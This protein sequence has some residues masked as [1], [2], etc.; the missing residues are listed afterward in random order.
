LSNSVADVLA[1]ARPIAGLCLLCIASLLAACGGGG[2]SSAVPTAVPPAIATQPASAV[3]KDGQPASFSAVADG[4]TPLSY[5]WQRNRRNIDGANEPSY[6]L[7]AAQ[8]ADNGVQ[9]TVV[10]TNPVGST[11][12][13]PATLTVDPIAPVITIPPL[14]QSINSGETVTFTV[15]ATGSAP[16][17][18]QWQKN[19]VDI[20]G[21]TASS[22]TTAAL[23][24]ADNGAGYGVLVT[25][26]AGSASSAIATLT[27]TPL[28]PVGTAPGITAA[29]QAQIVSDGQ[30]ATFSVAAAGSPPLA[31][32]WQRNGSNIAG[33]TGANFSIPAAALSDS[34]AQFLVVVTNSVGSVTSTAASLTVNPVAPSITTPPQ[35]QTVSDGV[36]PTFTVVASGSTVLHYQWK[37]SG[38]NVGTDSAAYQSPVVHPADSGSAYTVTVSNSAGS[39]TSAAATLTVNAVAPSIT[40]AP[41]NATVQD[42]Q[43]A[44]FSVAA[45]GSAPLAYQW[46][47]N[48]V[49]ISGATGT[50]YSMPAASVADSGAQFAVVVSNTAGSATSASALLT[51]NAVA[52]NIT[53]QPHAQ[54]VTDGASAT[55]TVAAGGT[56]VLHYQWMKSGANVG[57]DSPSYQTPAVQ[58][59]DSGS[60][61]T[62]TISNSAGSVTSAAAVLTV[63]PVAPS[64]T[65]APHAQTVSDGGTATF[66]VVAA[67]SA[68]LHYQWKKSGV[69]IGADAATY[70]TPVVHASDSGASY[71]VT[72]SNSAGNVTSPAATLT[73]GAVAPSITS[74][75]VSTSVQEGQTAV[76]TVVAAGTAPLS[77]Q[78][79]RGASTIGGAT[80]AT[81]SLSRATAQDDQA[82][83]QVV[84]TN[85]AG[86]ATS[87]IATLSVTRAP[88]SLIAGEIGGIGNVDGTGSGAE[89][90]LPQGVALDLNGNLYVADTADQTIRKLTPSGVV[91]TI[92][93]TA[94]VA[95]YADAAGTAARFNDPRSIAVDASGNLFVADAKNNAIRKI[96]PAGTV[97]TFAGNGPPGSANGTGTA[98]QFNNPTGVAV[99]GSA[100]VYVADANN[101][102]IRKINSAGAV[103]TLAGSPG[104]TGS[105]DGT[106]AAARFNVPS[107]VA[108]D[109]LGNV[110]V[111]DYLNS[112]IR[113][114]T[115][116]GVVTTLAG[117]AGAFGSND[118]TGSAATFNGVSGVAVDGS[119]VVYV[120]ETGNSTV[121]RITPTGSVTTLAG[122]A[123]FNGFTNG[124]GSAARFEGPVGVAADGAGNVYVADTTNNLIR[125][126]N[127]SGQVQTLAGSLGGRGTA[128]GTA[129]A[130]RF[131]D[132]HGIASDAAGNMY[133]V[134]HNNHTVRKITPAGVVTT[135]AGTAGLRGSAN[136]TGAAARFAYP[137]GIGT[138]LS[139]NVYVADSG[140]YTVRKITPAGVVTTLAGTAGLLGSNDGT[141]PTAR[142][143]FPTGVATDASGNVY[144]ADYGNSTIRKITP[145]GVVTTLAGTSGVS[146]SADGT[147]TAAQFN[148]PRGI[149][150]DPSG[151]VYVADRNNQ[152]VRK[153]TAAGVVTT[154]AGAALQAGSAD[155][156][157][158]AARFNS[159]DAIAV[160]AAFNIY[161]PD[162]LNHT[163]RAIT[164]AGVVTT[165]AGA[166]TSI[167]VTLG[168]L[169]GSLDGPTSVTVLPSSSAV[170]L[171]ITDALENA[172]LQITLP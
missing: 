112:T 147:G 8:L 86:A 145:S 115:P 54:T 19:G 64:I 62:V 118:A 77:Y 148:G 96:T 102:T 79:W 68:V 50:S 53:A 117:H 73:V 139:G 128:D 168:S 159:P 158:S 149:G 97:S 58:L 47:R 91:T 85:S 109:G 38:V 142:F 160:D 116:A 11:T 161:V 143:G 132:P 153:I 150:T 56:P 20:A 154:L 69:S 99:D 15:T 81:Y 40:T 106:G 10:V 36:A 170:E 5:Q 16:L 164:S 43:P 105:T 80:A 24:V 94:G 67:G 21:A 120:A 61:Y 41:A 104:T 89:F 12:S 126:I 166:P 135:F 30:P 39:V 34:G 95:G 144:V 136:G 110:T 171:A 51:V 82:T 27:V 1:W 119:G 100:N 131:D 162:Y 78:W 33:A 122:A 4:S 32:Q 75:P 9:F 55:F 6:A 129:G 137:R 23:G 134:D 172:I 14:A 127:S 157:G 18:F 156:N 65:T 108:V 92:A 49:N 70:Q 26:S 101:N 84:V 163:V 66:T 98:A 74:S 152:T 29:P 28:P 146:G 76:F 87:S 123:G 72:V 35:A 133:V 90:K 42:G 141:G 71:T 113:Q 46:Q 3:V 45:A 125:L 22:Y 130:A 83:F 93:G 124:S 48:G 60:A 121:R 13:D 165:V 17:S 103:S 59:A 25:N 31:Y 140:N 167:G 155:G 114:I 107:A 57:S 37:K 151:N 44:T 169:P 52:P 2:G 138:D 88:L 63:N 7:S 111:A